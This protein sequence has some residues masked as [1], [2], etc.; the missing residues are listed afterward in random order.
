MIQKH[1]QGFFSVSAKVSRSDFI[2]CPQLNS[3]SYTAKSAIWDIMEAY[4][5]TNSCELLFEPETILA[6]LTEDPAVKCA[7]W[8]IMEAYEDTPPAGQPP[9]RRRK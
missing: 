8:D 3:L 6:K 2:D 4:E 5:D 9:V 7:I 1:V